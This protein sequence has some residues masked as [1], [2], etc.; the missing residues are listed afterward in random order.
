MLLSPKDLDQ[1]Q[2]RINY[3]F[4]NLNLLKQ[5]LTHRSYLNEK[6]RDYSINEHNERLEF[7][8]DAVV[9]LIVTDYL[10]KNFSE[11][12]GYLTSLRAALVNYRN[13]GSIGFEIGLDKV[14]LLGRS[15]QNGSNGDSLPL[16]ANALEALIGAI[17]LDSGYE[18]CEIFTKNYLLKNLPDIIQ[19]G[20]YRDSKSEFQE[21]V[22]KKFKVTPRYNVISSIGKDHEKEFTSG[23]YI[24]DRLIATGNGRSKQDAETAAAQLAVKAIYEELNNQQNTVI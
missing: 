20:T 15:E 22:Q 10:Y 3:K 5:S 17:Y 7:L 21:V 1:F 16:V 24:K 13:M 11:A 4:L 19:T 18:S 23:V 9:E 12:E 6:N 8:G 2:E 14:L